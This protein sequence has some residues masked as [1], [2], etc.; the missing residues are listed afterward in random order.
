MTDFES[1]DKRVIF[2]RPIE[3]AE[4]GKGA[5]TYIEQL[6]NNCL[7][8][9]YNAHDQT[10]EEGKKHILFHLDSLKCGLS[11]SGYP[12]LRAD[13]EEA[14]TSVRFCQSIDDVEAARV[15]DEVALILK[16]YNTPGY[17]ER[18]ERR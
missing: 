3:R 1:A 13:A 16:K 9:I 18:E 2:R 14:M 17:K 15:S 5:S 7:N 6:C 4:P 10:W 8:A 12:L 11:C